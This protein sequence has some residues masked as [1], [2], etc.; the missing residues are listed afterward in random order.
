MNRPDADIESFTRNGGFGRRCPRPGI[1]APPARRCPRRSRRGNLVA[2]RA[3]GKRT[4]P[5]ALMETHTVRPT[6]GGGGW[7]HAH[8]APVPW[9]SWE[10]WRGWPA[11]PVAV[12]AELSSAAPAEYSP[13]HRPVPGGLTRLTNVRRPRGL[14]E[15]V[16]DRP[17][18]RSRWTRWWKPNPLASP[19][20]R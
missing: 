15:G 8:R 20:I 5:A 12:D 14:Q 11:L 17:G 16:S 7:G 3:G 2:W 13:G 9:Q 6:R 10:S 19:T 1:V 4:R 18:T